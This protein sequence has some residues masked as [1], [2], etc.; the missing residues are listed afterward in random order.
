MARPAK[1][2]SVK[3]KAQSTLQGNDIGSAY[4]PGERPTS[5]RVFPKLQNNGR[6]LV[7]DD[8]RPTL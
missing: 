7:K 5:Q 1:H 3:P 2:G 8:L 4:R 6:S